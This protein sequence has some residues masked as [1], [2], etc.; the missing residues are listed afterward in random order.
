MGLSCKFKKKYD[1]LVYFNVKN[2]LCGKFKILI[3]HFRYVD[4]TFFTCKSIQNSF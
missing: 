3:I 1:L 2:Y 4:T